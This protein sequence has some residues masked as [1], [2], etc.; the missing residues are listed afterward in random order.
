[1][2][3]GIEFSFP[4]LYNS[5]QPPFHT[6]APP[7]LPLLDQLQHPHLHGTDQVPL[8]SKLLLVHGGPALG[9][10]LLPLQ[11]CLQPGPLFPTPAQNEHSGLSICPEPGRASA[12]RGAPVG[13]WRCLPRRTCSHTPHTPH[14]PTHTDHTRAHV[15]VH[16]HISFCPHSPHAT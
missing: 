10:L 1:M 16:T 2:F 5:R 6:P 9:L 12:C 14:T 15:Y 13:S 7:R 4:G 11:L 3:S 8:P